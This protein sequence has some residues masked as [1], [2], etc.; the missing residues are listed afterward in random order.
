MGKYVL[1]QFG[2]LGEN[3]AFL[4]DGYVAGG[5][6]ATVARTSFSRQLLHYHRAPHGTDL[7]RACGFRA[8]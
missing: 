7:A 8:P 1:S 3:G 5:T 4:V 6:A 2:P